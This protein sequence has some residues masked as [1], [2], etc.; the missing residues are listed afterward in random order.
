MNR[1]THIKAQKFAIICKE[2]FENKHAVDKKYCKVRDHCHY[3]GEYRG[4]AHS[5]CNSKYSVLI[6]FSVV[7][8]NGCN[9][10]YNFFIKSLA[11]ELEQQCNGLGENT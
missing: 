8:H 6:K 5:I 10:D 3:T 9:Y 2:I 7:F 4:A 1:R 11:E